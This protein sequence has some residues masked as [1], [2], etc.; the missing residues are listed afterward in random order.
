MKVPLK[1]SDVYQ[2]PHKSSTISLRNFF[3]Y[4]SLPAGPCSMQEFNWTVFRIKEQFT[5][6]PALRYHA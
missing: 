6:Q 5:F 2:F 1:L 3:A 4:D